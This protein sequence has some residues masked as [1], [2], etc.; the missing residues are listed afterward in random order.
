MI[1][2]NLW[3][4]GFWSLVVL[5]YILGIIVLLHTLAVQ[6]ALIAALT[7]ANLFTW[8]LVLRAGFHDSSRSSG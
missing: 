8:T 3:F 5:A 7:S 6:D 4:V 2:V 1:K